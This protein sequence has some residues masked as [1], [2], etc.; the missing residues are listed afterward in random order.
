MSC[1][2]ILSRLSLKILQLA[3]NDQNGVN[4]SQENPNVFDIVNTPQDLDFKIL[5]LSSNDISNLTVMA[6]EGLISH[7]KGKIS[8]FSVL[9]GARS[10]IYIWRCKVLS[11]EEGN[12]N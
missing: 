2:L 7:A 4:S 12:N 9:V 8:S 5:S 11:S 1:S 3:S 6:K 10:C